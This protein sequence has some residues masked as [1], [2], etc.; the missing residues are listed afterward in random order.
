MTSGQTGVGWKCRI[1][2]AAANRVNKTWLTESVRALIANFFT[3]NPFQ[4]SYVQRCRA[5]PIVLL[6][7]CFF[8]GSWTLHENGLFY[9]RWHPLKNGAKKVLTRK[10]V[11]PRVILPLVPHTI[12]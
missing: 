6:V 4:A 12:P 5:Q 10:R 1:R 7:S 3:D 11:I 9:T 2:L 8:L